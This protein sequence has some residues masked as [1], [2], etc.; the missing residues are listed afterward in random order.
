MA[1]RF[2]V[3]FCVWLADKERTRGSVARGE[4]ELQLGFGADEWIVSSF[5]WMVKSLE[6]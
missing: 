6:S 1:E 2:Y 5:R 4:E 3:S